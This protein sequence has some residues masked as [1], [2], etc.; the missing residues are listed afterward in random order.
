MAAVKVNGRSG[1]ARKGSALVAGKSSRPVLGLV[2]SC[3]E[4]VGLANSTSRLLQNA[5]LNGCDVTP[6]RGN[7]ERLDQ[8]RA[9]RIPHYQRQDR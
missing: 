7:R 4:R 5:L 2:W 1:F 6:D 3:G 9:D 8:I